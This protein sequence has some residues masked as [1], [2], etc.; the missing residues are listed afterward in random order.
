MGEL[1]LATLSLLCAVLFLLLS[2]LLELVLLRLDVWSLCTGF[3]PFR[4][5]PNEGALDDNWDCE[6][7][8]SDIDI[9]WLT[10]SRS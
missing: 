5:D 4:K 8:R 2:R 10:D 6:F 9:G 3:C 1:E 7:R